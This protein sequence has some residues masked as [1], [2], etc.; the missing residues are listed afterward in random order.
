PTGHPVAG[1]P[2]PDTRWLD[3]PAG[4]NAEGWEMEPGLRRPAAY[5]MNSC[6]MPWMPGDT[7]NVTPPVRLA[8][9]ARAADTILIAEGHSSA[10][11]VHPAWMWTYCQ[12]VFT[13]STGKVGNFIFFDGHVKS[14]K[15]LATLFPL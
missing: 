5:A 15:W 6:S 2:T 8:E 7:K 1:T 10:A 14:K 4:G 11:D 12:G 9:V 13:H 3:P